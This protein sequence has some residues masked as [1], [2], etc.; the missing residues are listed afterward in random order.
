MPYIYLFIAL[1]SKLDF[2]S[3]IRSQTFIFDINFKLINFAFSEKM[4]LGRNRQT[5][6]KVILY[7]RVPFL[8]VEIR[9]PK[10][11]GNKVQKETGRPPYSLYHELENI[12]LTPATYA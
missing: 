7:L 2:Y 9:N 8:A 5:D 12:L 11:G 1:S 10:N 4:G 3:T 6:N